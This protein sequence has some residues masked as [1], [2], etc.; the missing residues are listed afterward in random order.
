ME[1]G[2]GLLI[3]EQMGKG[4]VTKQRGVK[5]R[6]RKQRS[7]SLKGKRVEAKQAHYQCTSPDAAQAITPSATSAETDGCTVRAGMVAVESRRDSLRAYPRWRPRKRRTRYLVVDYPSNKL[8]LVRGM[9]TSSPMPETEEA[10][11]ERIRSE[12]NFLIRELR[13]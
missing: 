11:L 13:L 12:P 7:L 10:L 8:L 2:L 6:Q 9:V 1:S 4:L 5:K 3:V